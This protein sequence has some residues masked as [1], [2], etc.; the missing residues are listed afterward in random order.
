[1]IVMT[2]Q[3]IN[4]DS[5]RWRGYF[6][7]PHVA[8]CDHDCVELQPIG[9]PELVTRYSAYN[10]D[11]TA[12]TVAPG[13]GGGGWL[14]LVAEAI[15]SACCVAIAGASLMRGHN[16][17]Q[18]NQNN[19]PVFSTPMRVEHSLGRNPAGNAPHSAPLPSTVEHRLTAMYMQV[20][21]RPA[22]DPDYASDDTVHAEVAQPS[23]SSII[24]P[25]DTDARVSPVDVTEEDVP[26]SNSDKV[27][28]EEGTSA[29]WEGVCFCKPRRSQTSRTMLASATNLMRDVYVHLVQHRIFSGID[30]IEADSPLNC[31]SLDPMGVL[32]SAQTMLRSVL[33][34]EL[35]SEHNLNMQIREVMATVLLMCYK[36]RAEAAWAGRP[37]TRSIAVTIMLQFMT[38][39]ET[40]MSRATERAIE[41]HMEF[42]EVELL[43]KMHVH[44]LAEDSPHSGFEWELYEHYEHVRSA[45]RKKHAKLLEQGD[46]AAVSE[47]RDLERSTRKQMLLALSGGYFF[48][49][50]ACI[51]QDCEML[52]TMAEWCDSDTMGRG[53]AYLCIQAIFL[54]QKD[55]APPREQHA[56]TMRAAALFASNAHKLSQQCVTGL[57]KRATEQG[58]HPCL[59]IIGERALQRLCKSLEEHL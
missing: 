34:E 57:R 9:T 44:R 14:T 10:A 1:M 5:P 49:H 59:Q 15:A 26:A 52:E 16:R 48:Y 32:F 4:V 27:D 8:L 2:S 30:I 7:S 39:S 3:Q 54:L 38:A 53:I 46:V 36:L 33:T 19:N 29:M 6:E 18:Q 37:G 17:Q 11:A 51:N 25:M 47:W 22:L 35:L 28:E 55:T 13:D 42:L 21:K 43:T 24:D 31:G 45:F 58:F 40:P 23:P 50:A 20:K 56:S 41:S 12:G